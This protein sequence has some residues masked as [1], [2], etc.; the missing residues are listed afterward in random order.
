M[1]LKI[2]YEDENLLV[3]DKLAGVV[4]DDIP[5]RVHRLDK[6]TSGVLLVAKNDEAL[7][8]LQKQFQ[9]RKV[10]KKYIALVVG[11]IKNQEG[12]I[13]T[14][15][16]RSPKDR[17]KQKVYL[18]TEPSAKRTRLRE[19]INKYRVLQRFKDYTLLEVEPQSGRK[20]QIR[21]HLAYL[22]NPIAGDKLYGFKN[23]P[24]PKGLNRQFL[25]ARY[26]KIKLMDGK[27]KE[28]K[29]DLPKDLK[30]V[31]EKLK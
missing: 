14:L 10:E 4:A 27:E 22:G 28:F 17:R 3:A 16:G 13:E 19:A 26:L 7:E 25:H 30:N 31:I 29:S 1:K 5:K 8:F 24:C 6:D 2:I 12:M 21:A 20:H 23:Q 11:N 18:P 9:K 15:L